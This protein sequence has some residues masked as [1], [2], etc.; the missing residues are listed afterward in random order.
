MVLKNFLEAVRRLSE[1][2]IAQDLAIQEMTNYLMIEAAKDAAELLADMMRDLINQMNAHMEEGGRP[3]RQGDLPGE[4]PPADG[5]TGGG[6]PLVPT[7]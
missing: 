3:L 1:Q 7:G 6:D 2:Q 4:G 5:P